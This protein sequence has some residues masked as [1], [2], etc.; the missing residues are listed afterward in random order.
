MRSATVAI[1]AL[2]AA[3]L[4]AG[5]EAAESQVLERG[6]YVLDFRDPAGRLDQALANR[7][8][9]TFFSVYPRLAAD[10][11]PDAARTVTF[12]IDPAYDGVAATWNDAIVY[13]PAWFDQHP[14]DID[15][16]T[17]ELMH[18]VQAYKGDD[19]PGWL[20]EGIADYVRARYGVDNPGAGW[21]MPE[22][23]PEHQATTGYRVTA[24]FLAWLETHGH[25]G[26]V[27]TLDGQLRDRTWSDASWVALTGQ[28]LDAL[29]A[30]YV[31]DPA[32]GAGA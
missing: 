2:F 23:K 13:N 15:V 24:R 18:V 9:E 6:G 26:I 8:A 3:L 10:F 16:V 14:G 22:P 30:A 20:V 5:A 12:T 17:H 32:L 29:W 19:T 11:N 28:P 21:T 7:M 4:P 25:A 31:A 1:A 27:R